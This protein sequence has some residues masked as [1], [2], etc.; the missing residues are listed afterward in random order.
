MNTTKTPTDVIELRDQLLQAFSL[1]RDDPRRFNQT[2]ELANV[3][4]KVISATKLKMEY[5]FMRGEEP[6]GAFLGKTSGRPLK[7]NAKLLSA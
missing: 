4:G 1:L 6:E 3:A 7:A 2:K 5:A